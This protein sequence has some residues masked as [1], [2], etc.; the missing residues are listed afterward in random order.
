MTFCLGTSP[1]CPELCQT[2][3]FI[4]DVPPPHLVLKEHY[5]E[6]QDGFKKANEKLEQLKTENT[7]LQRHLDALEDM[8]VTYKEKTDAIVCEQDNVICLFK[9]ILEH[10]KLLGGTLSLSERQ[11]IQTEIDKIKSIFSIGIRNKEST[12]DLI[13]FLDPSLFQTLLSKVKSQCPMLITLLEQL[14]LSSNASRSKIKTPNMK[15]KAGV[16]LLA[17]LIDVRDQNARN[18]VPILFGL[19]CLS[20]GAGPSLIGVLQHLGLSESHSVL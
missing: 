15:M 4:V 6:L 20:F 16:H 10:G 5:L 8:F 9:D 14:V 19:L 18:D 1:I 11:A 2:I 7:E 17:S 12:Q 13:Q 3:F